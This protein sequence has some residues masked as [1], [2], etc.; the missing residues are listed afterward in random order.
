MSAD[1]MQANAIVRTGRLLNRFSYDGS[2]WAVSVFDFEGLTAAS[3]YELQIR[4]ESLDLIG[5]RVLRTFP[6]KEDVRSLRAVVAS[7]MDDGFKSEA[8]DMWATVSWL[9]PDWIFLIGDTVYSDKFVGFYEGPADPK[10]MFERYVE[11]RNELTIYRQIELIPVLASWDDHD[12]GKNDGDRTFRFKVEAKKIFDAF[13]PKLKIENWYDVGPGVSSRLNFAGQDI[14]LLDDRSFR[15][16]NRWPGTPKDPQTHFGKEQEKWL[17]DSIAKDKKPSWIISGD[18]FF[19]GYSPYESYQGSHSDSFLQFVKKF[20]KVKIPFWLIS[21]DRH[22]MELMQIE[23]EQFGFKT[24]ELSTSGIHAKV[25]PSY[26]DKYPN[27]RQLVGIA[28]K[29]NFALVESTVLDQN[30]LSLK[31]T[32]YTLEKKILFE[33]FFTVRR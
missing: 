5:K 18:Q 20:K 13:F 7:C 16:P 31:L 30:A 28:E 25:F 3:K 24:L 32:G 29:N 21:G 4:D 17:F 8:K 22:M 2:D 9:R 15:S 27:E 11:T 12:Y 23:E 33:R 1:L 19:G 10:T 6:K 14:F 26:W